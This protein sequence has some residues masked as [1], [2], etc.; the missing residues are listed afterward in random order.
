MIDLRGGILAVTI[1]LL[2]FWAANQ[3]PPPLPQNAPLCLQP[4]YNK[5]G[6]MVRR[7]TVPCSDL[8]RAEIT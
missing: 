8:N 4:Y 6:D 5:W 3:P 7:E 1:C 2:I